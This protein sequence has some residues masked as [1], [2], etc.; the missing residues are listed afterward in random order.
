MAAHH[1]GKGVA[2]G[3]R[4]AGKLHL[5]RLPDQLLRMRSA[6]E[7]RE[8]GGHREL[9]EGHGSCLRPW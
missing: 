2:V 6:A 4:D 1:A 7:E 8:I 5:R 9:G 3:D